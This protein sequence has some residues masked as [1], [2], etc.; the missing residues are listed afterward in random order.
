MFR[1]AAVLIAFVLAVLSP[2]VTE[3]DCSA[4]A[5]HSLENAD[6]GDIAAWTPRRSAAVKRLE[7]LLN[8]AWS[9]DA[10][11]PLVESAWIDIGES[12]RLILRDDDELLRPF[13]RLAAGSANP[14][15]PP[16]RAA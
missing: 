16:T 10:P 12:S 1:V 14:R 7:Q 5:T 4:A 8:D 3:S 2:P 6:V 11:P 13:A 9:A 15:G